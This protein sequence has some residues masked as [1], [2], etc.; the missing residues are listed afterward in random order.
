MQYGDLISVV[1]PCFNR[2]RSIERAVRG[3]LL[4]SYQNLELIVVDDAS[5][6][7]SPAIVEAIDDS[8]LRLIR[9]ETNQGAAAARNTGVAA[10]EGALIAFQDSDDNWLPEKLDVQMRQFCSLPEDY[11]AVFC[12]TIIYGR[13]VDEN[14]RRRYG[15]RRAS[16]EPGSKISPRSG[17]MASAFLMT[18]FMGPQAVILKKTAHIAAGGFDRRLKNNNDWDFHIRLSQRGKIAFCDLPLTVAYDTP[19]SISKDFRAKG[20]SSIVIFGKV[21]RY[22]PDTSAVALH[23]MIVHRH[24]IFRGKSRSARRFLIKAMIISPQSLHLYP[25]FILSFAPKL[26]AILLRRRRSNFSRGRFISD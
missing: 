22:A 6:D 17:D 8:R 15:A 10:A 14:G 11:V 13:S 25:R 19:K 26:Y 1:I 3:V 24:L 18:N 9:H 16:C 12:T 20:F 4:Q 7:D 5:T 23:A 21:K 2:A